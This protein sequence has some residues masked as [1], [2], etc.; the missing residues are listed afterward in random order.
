FTNFD[1]AGGPAGIDAFGRQRVSNPEMIFNSK[2]V[3]D[4]Q[5][6]Y[7]D[8]IQESGSGTA[9]A[10]DKNRASSTLSVSANTV[11]K[12]TRQTF[13]RFN[14]QAGKAQLIMMT[15]ILKR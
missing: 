13:M 14:Y 3:F 1:F 10:Y 2:Q 7:W 4:N 8:D 9:S 6:I 11:G 12:R 15:G 5:S